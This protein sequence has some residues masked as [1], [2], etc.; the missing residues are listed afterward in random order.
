MVFNG[1]FF[2]QAQP[3]TIRYTAM[4][5]IHKEMTVRIIG[6]SFYPKTLEITPGTTIAWIDENVFNYLASDSCASGSYVCLCARRSNP[7]RE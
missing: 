4:D 3:I 5:P 2:W 6:K 1:I 7:K